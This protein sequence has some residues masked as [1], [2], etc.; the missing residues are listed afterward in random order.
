MMRKIKRNLYKY[1]HVERKISS[2]STDDMQ[3]LVEGEIISTKDEEILD[4]VSE[5]M[6]E[7]PESPGGTGVCVI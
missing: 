1:S 4:D 3:T 5:V 6:K 2:P 7:R